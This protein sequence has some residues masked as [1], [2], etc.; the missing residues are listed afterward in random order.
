MKMKTLL[1]TREDSEES[2]KP[3]WLIQTVTSCSKKGIYIIIFSHFLLDSKPINA[4]IKVTC[5][6]L[7]CVFLI[8]WT[9]QAK[10][11]GRN[12][13]E[14]CSFQN[15]CFSFNTATYVFQQIQPLVSPRQEL[16]WLFSPAAVVAQT[17]SF[18]K[19]PPGNLLLS[20]AIL[21]AG[22]SVNK[23]LL[24]FRHMGMLIYSEPTFYS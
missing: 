20:F 13:K 10:I 7:S 24:V 18:G 15:F 11:P 1:G 8:D 14:L 5:M 21:C 3:R 12:P 2:N 19:F 23:V 6:P 4:C 16:W 22:A 9:G 17:H